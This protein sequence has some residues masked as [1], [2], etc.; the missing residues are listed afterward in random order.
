MQTLSLVSTKG[1]A[2][3]TSLACAIAVEAG[4]VVLDVDP[5]R[6]AC[7]WRDRRKADSPA[8]TDVAPDRLPAV[9]QVAQ[10]QDVG[11]VVID[12]PPRSSTAVLAAARVADLVLLPCRPQFIDLETVPITRRSLSVLDPQPVVVV[13]LTAVP[14]RGTRADQSRT[15]LEASGLRVCPITLGH[16]AAWGDAGALGLTPTEHDP[17]GRAAAEVRNLVRWVRGLLDQPVLAGA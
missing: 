3:K 8:V 9:L 6:S 16:R 12:T 1:G 13:V 17:K 2:G 4:G 15:A 7:S 5:Q 10:E 11:L 14:P